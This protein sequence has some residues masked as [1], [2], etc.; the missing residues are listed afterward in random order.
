MA[1]EYK[2]RKR[3][4]NNEPLL[5]GLLYESHS[6]GMSEH[7]SQQWRDPQYLLEMPVEQL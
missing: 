7:S 2:T 5:E 3:T 6:T 4:S 1:L